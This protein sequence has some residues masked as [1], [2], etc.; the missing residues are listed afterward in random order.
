MTTVS[1]HIPGVPQ[2]KAR[3]RSYVIKGGKRSGSIGHYT[4][5]T[6]KE[7]EARAAVLGKMAMQGKQPFAGPLELILI[8]WMPVPES[9]SKKKTQRALDGELRPTVK[10]DF[11]NIA[12]IL[13]DAFNKVVWLDDAQV[14]EAT[15]RKLYS[16]TPQVVAHVKQ[17]SC[18]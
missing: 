18:R 14:V 10:P 17:L 8:A 16:S 4:P 7:W 2:G 1:V 6:T 15:V 3:A 12:K 13:C 11:D 9:W 5:P